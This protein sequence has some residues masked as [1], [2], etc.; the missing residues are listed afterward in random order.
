[1]ERV[2]SWSNFEKEGFGIWIL[3]INSQVLW[4]RD[5]VIL[6]MPKADCV[7]LTVTCVYYTKTTG[8]V[9]ENKDAD[10]IGLVRKHWEVIIITVVC[11]TFSAIV[12]SMPWL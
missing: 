11:Y 7:L 8:S 3:I 12:Y 1:M 5:A 9:S 6:D 4:P 10:Q 2:V